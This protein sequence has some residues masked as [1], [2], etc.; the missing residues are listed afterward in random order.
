MP[1]SSPKAKI[2]YSSFA[3]NEE[4]KETRL[5]YS[6]YKDQGFFI[7]DLKSKA[8]KFIDTCYFVLIVEQIPKTNDFFIVGNDKPNYIRIIRESDDYEVNKKH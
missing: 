2:F 8:K 7:Y 5:V 1:S 3:Y 6:T 4:T